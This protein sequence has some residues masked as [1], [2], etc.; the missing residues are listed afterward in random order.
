MT[1]VQTCA[2]PISRCGAQA[3]LVDTDRGEIVDTVAIP[4]RKGG[5]LDLERAAERGC[6]DADAEVRSWLGGVLGRV[7][8]SAP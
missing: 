7:E 6:R 8:A 2:L 3:A 5:H 4:P 1:G